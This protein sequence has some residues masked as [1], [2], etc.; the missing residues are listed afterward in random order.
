MSHKEPCVGKAGVT[1]ER[2][3]IC[4]AHTGHPAFMAK[5]TVRRQL[6]DRRNL[7]WFG[8]TISRKDVLVTLQKLARPC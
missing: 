1:E 4:P 3:L 5:G 8:V 6:D 7:C 2:P